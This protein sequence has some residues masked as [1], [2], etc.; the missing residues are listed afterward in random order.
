[1]RLI[2]QLP[3]E[4]NPQRF[5]DYLYVQ[6]IDNKVE[7]ADG[8][9]WNVWVHDERQIEQAKLVLEDFRN[10]PDDEKFRKATGTARQQRKQEQE[11]HKAYQKRYLTAAKIF[12]GGISQIGILT[13]ILIAI[14]VIVSL[15]TRTL[16][17]D[18]GVSPDI[19]LL[20]YLYI[21]QY[22]VIDPSVVPWYK[23]F[24]KSRRD[25]SGGSSPRCLFTLVSYICC[26][27]CYG[28]E[29]WGR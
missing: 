5:S 13:G 11:E 14:S 27:T 24:L 25:R 16:F 4:S 20:R 29:T 23:D 3:H 8:S 15:L 19:N 17:I 22:R 1:M 28:S 18:F 12:P 21:S 10:N 9:M 6:G 2:G 7:P 26:L